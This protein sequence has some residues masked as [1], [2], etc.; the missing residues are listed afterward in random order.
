MPTYQE[1]IKEREQFSKEAHEAL[2]QRMD[3]LQSGLYVSI[4]NKVLNSLETDT[5][6]LI[7]FST[8]NVRTAGRSLVV[9]ASYRRST[10]GVVGW[11]VNQLIKLFDLNTKYI[12]AVATAT[13]SQEA[14]TRK[15][16]LLNLGYD[17]DKKEII[18]GG[19]LDA[20]AGQEQVKNRV[21]NRINAAVQ[22]R[23]SL[24]DFRKTFEA[25]FLDTKD[26]LGYPKRY[27]NQKTFDIFQRYDRAAQQ[28]YA[29]ELKLNWRVYSGTVMKPSKKGKGTRSFCLQRVGN[30]YSTAEIE[31]WRDLKFAGRVDPYDPFIDCG[32]INCRHHHSVISDEIKETLEKRGKKVNEYNQLPPGR[33]LK[34]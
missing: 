2:I 3:A 24:A 9:W 17:I 29:Q 10:G 23:V 22:S 18:K 26:G 4:T 1:L 27:F 32:S 7:K 11:L 12:R 19:W 34:N 13:E 21:I 33:T 6:G 20:L 31:K 30:I 25:D 15:R 5:D 16:L 14:R 8:A 28:V